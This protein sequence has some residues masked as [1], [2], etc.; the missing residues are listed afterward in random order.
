MDRLE[1]RELV[2]FVAVAEQMHFGR[3]AEELGI[4]QPPLS[5][6]ISR[7]ERRIGIRLFERTSRRVDLTDAGEVFLH[8]SRKALAALDTVVRRTRQ[9][10]RPK[11]LLV[12]APPGTGAGL[13]A[14]IFEEYRRGAD[15]VPVEVV[16]TAELGASLRDG[17]ADLA[18]MCG[19][20]DLDGLDTI[21]LLE[22][23][24]VALLPAGHPLASRDSLTARE[25]RAEARY[26]EDAP[27]VGL[28]ELI[29]RVALGELVVVI[30]AGGTSRLGGSVVAVPV[31]DVPGDRMVL[32]WPHANLSAARDQFARAAVAVVNR[33]DQIELM[34]PSTSSS[35]PVM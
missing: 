7:L 4:G 15:P 10:V 16:F 9:A 8:E 5:R 2:Y 31:V 23:P 27:P 18:L 28:D 25:L 29:D 6:A 33:L 11:R 12:A 32:A 19:N 35:I 22:E 17:L 21:D 3:A 34:P 1:V 30:G 14:R 20:D 24:P 26:R 13:L